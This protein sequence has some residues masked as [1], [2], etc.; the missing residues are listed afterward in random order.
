M[1][2]E[3]QLPMMHAYWRLAQNQCRSLTQACSKGAEGGI[4]PQ[5]LNFILFPSQ[6][7]LFIFDGLTESECAES[8]ITAMGGPQPNENPG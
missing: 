6:N 8:I 1:L 7:L 5:S 2:E 4:C 3:R